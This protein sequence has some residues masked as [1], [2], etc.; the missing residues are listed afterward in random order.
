MQRRDFTC[1]MLAGALCGL[2]VPLAANL[3]R[4]DRDRLLM[5]PTRVRLLIGTQAVLV[6]WFLVVNPGGFLGLDLR[7]EVPHYRENRVD[8]GALP[9]IGGLF[10]PTL[11]QRLAG[12]ALVGPVHLFRSMLVLNPAAALPD[13]ARTVI[14]HRSESWEPPGR[15]RKVALRDLPGLGH[16]FA[17]SPVGAAYAKGRDLLVI[18]RPTLVREPTA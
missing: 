16:L 1:A 6:S 8:A 4:D 15:P 11:A 2:P 7:T 17:G 10:R 5:P 18:V 3:D 14:A 12:A 13:R 9:L